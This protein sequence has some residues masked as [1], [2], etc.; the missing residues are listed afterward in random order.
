MRILCVAF[1]LLFAAPAFA[2]VT[3]VEILS[4]ADLTFAGYEKIVGRV[5]FAVDPKDPRNAVVV[6]LDKAPRNAAGKVEFSSDFYIVR[7]KSGGNGVAIVD[8]VNRGGK[9]V[10]RNYNRVGTMGDPDVG[11][12]FLFTRGFTVVAVGWEFDLPAAGPPARSAAVQAIGRAAEDLVRIQV[13]VATEG[14]APITGIVRADF[15]ADGPGPSRRITEVPA[16][17]PVAGA[18]TDATLTVRDSLTGPATT[19]PRTEWSLAGTTVTMTR[20]FEPGRIYQLSFRAAN[21]PVAGLGLAAVRDFATWIK[22]D[23]SALTRATHVYAFGN[24][25]SGRFLRTFLYQGFNAD[26]RGRQVLDATIINI[27]GAAR[28]DVNRRW[29]TPT[30]AAAMATEFPFADRALEDP[31][32]RQKD[33]LL[34]NARAG[35]HQPKVFYT[36][37]DVEY[38]S[39]HGR[40]AALVHTSP[41]GTRDLE[42]P[43]NARAYF[44][45][46]TQHGPAA[47]PPAAA[48]NGQQ[49]PNPMDYWWI[50]RS[51]LVAMDDWVR[52]GTTPP[53]TTV[54]RLSAG[55]LVQGGAVAFPDIPGVQ[56]PKTLTA[57]ARVANPFLA[58]G[59]GAGT[60]I[61]LLVPQVDAD[62]NARAGIRLPEQAVPLGTYTG[63]N[64]RNPSIGGTHQIVSLLG[65]YVPFARTK[66]ER[67]QRRDPRL[68]I[69]ERYA[70]RERYASLAREVA[71]GLVRDRFLLPEDV[72]PVMRRAGAHW[73]VLMGTVTT[74][75]RE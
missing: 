72:D 36:N 65:S 20:A 34:E 47:F 10:I 61:P 39:S 70:S 13:P 41:D 21:P 64:F 2:E 25:Q 74:S 40:A 30:I 44:F 28:L 43:D 63:W 73:D 57:S 50:Q 5:F 9:T 66:A 1:A 46:G 37:S 69:E 8:I 7:P 60:P 26:E 59:A 12:G 48:G 27:A 32:S 62:G 4:R 15:T 52:K 67:E 33:G 16:Y 51:L 23:A 3:R 56:S 45:A 54:P 49:R 31:V 35:K 6:D 17:T 42:L 29:A 22:H 53:P 55:T 24:S 75:S 14:G 19:V 71:N 11:D 68:S 38:W 18:A 58:G